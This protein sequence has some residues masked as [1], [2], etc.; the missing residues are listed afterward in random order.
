MNA[1]TSSIVT[2]TRHQKFNLVKARNQQDRETGRRIRALTSWLDS[3]PSTTL[4]QAEVSCAK[5][6][7]M[8]LE[9]MAE[10][11]AG[12]SDSAHEIGGLLASFPGIMAAIDLRPVLSDNMPKWKL[13]ELFSMLEQLRNY[14]PLGYE[15]YT[16]S[17]WGLDGIGYNIRKAKLTSDRLIGSD[18][19]SG[20]EWRI[21]R[22]RLYD[23]LCGMDECG[24]GSVEVLVEGPLTLEQ[25][26]AMSAISWIGLEEFEVELQQAAEQEAS[27]DLLWV[28]A[29]S[30]GLMMGAIIDMTA[31]G[32]R[33]HP[34]TRRLRQQ[35][36][37]M[38]LRRKVRDFD[39]GEPE[40]LA[41]M[42]E[43]AT[44]RLSLAKAKEA[45]DADPEKRRKNF[46]GTET[47]EDIELKRARIAMEAVI[48][49]SIE[50][51]IDNLEMICHRI[52]LHEMGFDPDEQLRGL[53][54]PEDLRDLTVNSGGFKATRLQSVLDLHM[55]WCK[56]RRSHA[57]YLDGDQDAEKAFREIVEWARQDGAYLLEQGGRTVTAHPLVEGEKVFLSR[58]GFSGDP[59]ENDDPFLRAWSATLDEERGIIAH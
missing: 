23:R 41:Y 17:P 21:T 22:Q 36:A 49:C 19:E 47:L 5:A 27:S 4:S 45:W 57:C 54:R 25:L 53:E 26:A 10:G 3:Q 52:Q 9:G 30:V 43:Q 44:G 11:G 32:L 28:H 7:I 6:A 33:D 38:A 51:G 2:N 18:P 50:M 58:P 37:G 31:L 15:R 42:I 40:T 39:G 16:V 20:E 12:D 35:L 56:E 13:E 8:Y 55:E 14:S 24:H 46:R 34:A 48:N 1:S 29:R 59:R